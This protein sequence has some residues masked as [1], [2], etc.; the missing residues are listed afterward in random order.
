MPISDIV[1]RKARA[2]Q[3]AQRRSMSVCWRK[4]PSFSWER[5]SAEDRCY[6]IQ[7]RKSPHFSPP[8]PHCLGTEVPPKIAVS[9]FVRRVKGRSSRKIQPEFEHIRKRYWGQRFWA[10]GYFLTASG[11]ITDTAI[12]NYPNKHIETPPGLSPKP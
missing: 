3:V 8:L 4:P 10:R 7:H 11:N 5:A 9:D 6:G 2:G 1:M 12:L